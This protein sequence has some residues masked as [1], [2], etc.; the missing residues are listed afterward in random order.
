[1]ALD[2]SSEKAD[3]AVVNGDS[4]SL[5]FGKRK[6]QGSVEKDDSMYTDMI[7]QDLLFA[8]T[9]VNSIL[10]AKEEELGPV[11]TL[12]TPK[13]MRVPFG[14]GAPDGVWHHRNRRLMYHHLT[15]HPKSDGN[16]A[17]SK[18]ISF[19]YDVSA[20]MKQTPQTPSRFD[21]SASRLHAVQDKMSSSSNLTIPDSIIPDEYHIVKSKAVIGLDYAD[22]KLTTNLVDQEKALR[23]FPSL[24]PNKR[25]EVVQL[26][27]TMDQMLAKA[28]VD[29]VETEVKGPTQIHNLLEIIKKEQQIYDVVFHEVIRQSSIECVERGQLLSKLRQRYAD[30]L[31]RIPRQIKS[32]HAEV[33]AQR[34]LDRRLTDELMRFKGSI[35]NLTSELIAVR[36]HDKKITQEAEIAQ[37]DLAQALKESQ[38]NANL[39]DEYHD[40]YELQRSRLEN[41]V[42]LLTY[43]RDLW[44]NASYSLALKIISENS[45]ST[46][47]R[48]HVTEKAWHKLAVHFNVMISDHDTE[49]LVDLQNHVE[50]WRDLIFNFNQLLEAGD[51]KTL[52]VLTRLREEIRHWISIF[53]DTMIGYYEDTDIRTIRLPSTDFVESLQADISRWESIIGDDSE[54]FGGDVLLSNQELLIK[55]AKEVEEWTDIGI[56]VYERHRSDSGESYEQYAVMN[57]NSDQF[58]LMR[59]QMDIRITGENGTAKGMISLQNNLDVW[60]TRLVVSMRGADVVSDVEWLKFFDLLNEYEV[61]LGE[62]MNSVSSI[63]KDGQDNVDDTRVTVEEMIGNVQKWLKDTLNGIEGEN[64]KMSAQISTIHTQMVHWMVQMLLLLAPNR[65]TLIPSESS[66]SAGCSLEE[67]TNKCVDLSDHSSRVTAYLCQCT[68]AIVEMTT[69][70]KKDAG[71]DDADHE[72]RDFIRVKSECKEW[73]RT[74][75]LLLNT[76]LDKPITLLDE[77][78]QA[79]LDVGKFMVK[80]EKGLHEKPEKDKTEKVTENQ[81]TIA[82]SSKATPPHQ[83]AQSKATAAKDST[84]KDTPSQNAYVTATKESTKQ[85]TATQNADATTAREIS[86]QVTTNQN[87]ELT[88]TDETTKTVAAARDAESKDETIPGTLTERRMTQFEIIGA[89]EN[90]EAAVLEDEEEKA[91]Q[92]SAGSLTPPSSELTRKAYDAIA[93]MDLF[94]EQLLHTEERAQQAEAKTMELEELLKAANEKIRGLERQVAET[95]KERSDSIT[96]AVQE[97]TESKPSTSEKL[98]S[99]S[100]MKPSTPETGR[101]SS[102]R[103][104]TDKKKGK[105]KKK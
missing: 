101:R 38:K 60:N 57:N 50:R 10:K 24:T 77:T 85:V 35:G 41:Q 6:S 17:G 62:I 69:Q 64:G 1:M 39:V 74:C 4:N 67:L 49:S 104:S 28:G 76:K 44:C 43:E 48:L 9:E 82:A 20:K 5:E 73:I 54:R 7:P 30:L 96:P 94:Q 3:V 42:S 26:M 46:A 2:V 14:K 98:R 72:M 16:A 29:D 89:D 87:V 31:N 71:E 91:A 66:L 84:K 70:N 52:A 100:P 92:G 79:R 99:E 55:M 68:G 61:L 22:E 103:A 59:K 25:F 80:K 63:S 15:K 13:E 23:L 58:H 19:L 56:T 83:V 90:V 40:L 97:V 21:K 33:M 45:L 78:V 75:Q 12:K 95:E 8:L 36:E 32:L 105:A 18:D 51:K 53:E 27:R 102:S 34:S 47:K 81:P 93:E 11:K 86:K 88:T 37:I 65:D